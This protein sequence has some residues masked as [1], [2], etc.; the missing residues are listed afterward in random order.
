MKNPSTFNKLATTP[1]DTDQQGN[2]CWEDIFD[3]DCA[4]SNVYAAS[5]VA[6]E[7]IK[8]MPCASGLEV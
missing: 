2:P 8:S 1:K 5:F 7:W 4:M 3:D 6:A